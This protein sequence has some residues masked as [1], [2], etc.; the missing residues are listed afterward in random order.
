MQFNTKYAKFIIYIRIKTRSNIIPKIFRFAKQSLNIMCF[1]VFFSIRARL[2]TLKQNILII[3]ITYHKDKSDTHKNIAVISFTT[4]R[5]THRL[6]I[7]IQL[8]Y[9][10]TNESYCT[11]LGHS[12]SLSGQNIKQ[13]F[14]SYGKLSRSNSDNILQKLY[15]IHSKK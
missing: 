14:K 5:Q 3:S 2:K 11:K 10:S 6:G 8:R 4:I 1:I 15:S 12:F 7:I 9:F 13:I